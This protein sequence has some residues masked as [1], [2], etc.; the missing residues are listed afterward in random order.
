MNL[1][2]STPSVAAAD[3]YAAE[4]NE[5]DPFYDPS[6]PTTRYVVTRYGAEWG[7]VRRWRYADRPELGEFGGAFIVMM[8]NGV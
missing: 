1:T 4:L 5:R 7:I 3:E 8:M 6:R 2:Y